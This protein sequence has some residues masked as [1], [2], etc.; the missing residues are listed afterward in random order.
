MNQAS[1]KIATMCQVLG[2]STSGYYG[3]RSRQPSNRAQQDN[4]YAGSDPRPFMSVLVAPTGCHGF[5]PN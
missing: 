1:Y 4:L 2:V 3:W 5:T